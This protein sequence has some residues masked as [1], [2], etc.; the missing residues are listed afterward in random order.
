MLN[1]SITPMFCFAKSSI[2]N[3]FPWP[4]MG[5]LC[6]HSMSKVSYANH[7]NKHGRLSVLSICPTHFRTSLKHLLTPL[8]GCVLHSLAKTLP[9]VYWTRTFLTL[10]PHTF[11]FWP[12]T[13][14]Q[15]PNLLAKNFAQELLGTPPILLQK[16]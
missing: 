7:Y 14:T 1:D 11:V 8:H 2:P 13:S 15:A 9:R 10:L 6:Y 3:T 16:N 12:K 5:E 4:L